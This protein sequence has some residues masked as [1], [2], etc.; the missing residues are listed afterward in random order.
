[1]LISFQFQRITL[2]CHCFS[3]QQPHIN[4][5]CIWALVGP[6]RLAFWFEAWFLIR[7]QVKLLKRNAKYV[8][9]GPGESFNLHRNGNETEREGKWTT[10]V[11]HFWRSAHFLCSPVIKYS[12][13]LD[14]SLSSKMRAVP[15]MSQEQEL[16]VHGRVWV[17]KTHGKDGMPFV[18][19]WCVQLTNLKTCDVMF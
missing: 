10:L 16:Q 17:K 19:P 2:Q 14:S 13:S 7:F 8:A 12:T 1:M 6:T 18:L 5:K 4:P 9:L 15:T 11:S 3:F